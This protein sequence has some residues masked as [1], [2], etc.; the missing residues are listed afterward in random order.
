M[1]NSHASYFH[2]T[3]HLFSLKP[4]TSFNEGGR[5]ALASSTSS[6]LDY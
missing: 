5:P 1:S 3:G 4:A 2:E 6:H